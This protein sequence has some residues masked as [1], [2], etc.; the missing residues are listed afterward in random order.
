MEV[1]SRQFPDPRFTARHKA[2]TQ[3]GAER[4]PGVPPRAFAGCPFGARERHAEDVQ[5]TSPRRGFLPAAG[6][7]TGLWK[8]TTPPALA[9]NLN[10]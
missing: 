10:L 6:L 5:A 4:N 3:G 1:P 8:L 9:P 7:A 2:T